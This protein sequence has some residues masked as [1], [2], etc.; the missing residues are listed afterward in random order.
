MCESL[1]DI[2]ELFDFRN[3]ILVAR[4]TQYCNDSICDITMGHTVWGAQQPVVS[5]ADVNKF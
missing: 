5:S 3:Y 4:L 1:V 2:H